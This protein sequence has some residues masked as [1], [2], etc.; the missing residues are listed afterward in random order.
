MHSQTEHGRNYD[1]EEGEDHGGLEGRRCWDKG[2]L[3]LVR[4]DAL[5]HEA[6]ADGDVNEPGQKNASEEQHTETQGIAVAAL[7]KD[8]L[9][10]FAATGHD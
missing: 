5:H 9:Q 7:G 2:P 1:A 10:I 4:K 6:G 8:L 3:I